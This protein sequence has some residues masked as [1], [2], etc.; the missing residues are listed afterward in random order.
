MAFLKVQVNIDGKTVKYIKEPFNMGNDQVQAFGEK[1]I[2][3]RDIKENFYQIKNMEKAD[4]YGKTE[5]FIKETFGKI[6]CT[7]TA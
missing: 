2:I 1:K 5:K 4:T 6:K 3:N 7:A